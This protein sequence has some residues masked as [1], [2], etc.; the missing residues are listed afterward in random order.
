MGFITLVRYSVPFFPGVLQGGSLIRM[1][2]LAIL[3]LHLTTIF[4]LEV[5]VYIVS[6]EPDADNTRK[7]QR[8]LAQAH[9]SKLVRSIRVHRLTDLEQ[10]VCTL[11][12]RTD[13]LALSL[14]RS[15]R[16][17]TSWHKHVRGAGHY[18][19]RNRIRCCV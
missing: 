8:N 16:L 4:G 18:G 19:D 7:I 12:N 1:H 15:R 9:R 14:G 3:V 5:R 10:R 2:S 11:S 17:V 6:F 13:A